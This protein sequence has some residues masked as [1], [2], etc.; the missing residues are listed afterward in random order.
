MCAA[1]EQNR[2]PAFGGDIR[3]KNMPGSQLKR[4][5]RAI[6]AIRDQ[7]ELPLE[8][9]EALTE[10][11]DAVRNIEGRLSALE[12]KG[13]P[14]ATVPRSVVESPQQTRSPVLRCLD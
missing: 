1:L 3:G 12:G 13:H 14:H 10:I 7:G 4:A 9:A 5:E 8:T 6:Q 2:S 11:V